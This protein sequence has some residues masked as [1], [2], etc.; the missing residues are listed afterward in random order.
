[1]NLQ[2]IETEQMPPIAVETRLI[3][4]LKLGFKVNASIRG[5][6][7]AFSPLTYFYIDLVAMNSRDG[8]EMDLGFWPGMTDD[9]E[10]AKEMLNDIKTSHPKVNIVHLKTE[11]LLNRPT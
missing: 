9:L 1:M 6:R 5:F 11:V 2:E 7:V 4:A 8:N 3:D 10:K